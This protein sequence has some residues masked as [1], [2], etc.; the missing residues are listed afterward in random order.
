MADVRES[1]STL[2]GASQEGLAL[3]S[4]QQGDSVAAKNGQLAFG[5]MDASGNAKAAPIKVSG[6]A[7]ADNVPTLPAVDTAG[8]LIHTPVKVAGDAPGN[9]V[10]AL[11]FIDSTG[12]LTYPQL[13][14]AGAVP[15][16]FDVGT[17]LFARG[18][19]VG[20]LSTVTVATITLATATVYQGI[21]AV[22][23]C[24]RDALFQVIWND[25]G[26]ETILAEALCGPGSLTASIIIEKLEF[27]SGATGTQELLVKANNFNAT[28]DFRATIATTGA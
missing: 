21:E 13:N 19:A 8:N 7:P 27:T 2:E 14:A 28:S 4:V 26:S 20:N 24:F 9:A 25:D 23:S 11:S 12:D 3:R 6:A 17:D 5:F 15:V 10:P 22:V 18:T 1:F 16:S